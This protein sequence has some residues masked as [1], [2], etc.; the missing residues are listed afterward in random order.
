MGRTGASLDNVP[1]DLDGSGE[2]AASLSGDL[3]GNEVGLGRGN[4]FRTTFGSQ[5][6]RKQCS[7]Y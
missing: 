6:F 2:G 7:I 1:V 5:H 3:V 4:K